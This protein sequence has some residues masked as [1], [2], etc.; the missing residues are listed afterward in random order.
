[1]TGMLR[2][3]RSR[4]ALCGALLFLLGLWGGL[5]AFVGPYF[6]FAYRTDEPWVLT[7]DRIWLHIAPAVATGLGGLI[8][9]FAANRITGMIGGGLAALGGAW[10]IVGAPVSRLWTSSGA[11]AS[12]APLG[13]DVRQVVEQLAFFLALGALV[14]FLAALALGRFSV[15]G[16]KEA[17]LSAPVDQDRHTPGRHERPEPP[18]ERLPDWMAQPM[19]RPGTP[20]MGHPADR[21]VGVPVPDGTPT[22]A[23]MGAGTGTAMG[24]PMGQQPAGQPM[25]APVAPPPAG[26]PM[27]PPP[28]ARP[29]GTPMEAP[30]MGQRAA[31]GA[32]P[33]GEPSGAPG[34]RPTAPAEAQAPRGEWPPATAGAQQ[35]GG[36]ADGNQVPSGRTPMGAAPGAPGEQPARGRY[37]QNQDQSQNPFSAPAPVGVS[38]SGAAGSARRV[39]GD[40]SD[41]EGPGH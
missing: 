9:L 30:S 10:F 7:T 26:P 5:I 27:A 36:T 15:F 22:G 1:M 17:R 20:P 19:D 14:V 25:G 18:A 23:G 11:E 31:A 12:G 2:V 40:S 37:S 21:P 16:V 34:E 6:D 38:S 24:T 39:A 32:T 4:G 28:G 3:P 8:V 29:A 33:G 35:S 13:G 41:R